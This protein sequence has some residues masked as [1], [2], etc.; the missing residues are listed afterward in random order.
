MPDSF[1]LE[2]SIQETGSNILSAAQD[3]V[4][5]F[6]DGKRWR[7]KM[8]EWA[9]K[10]ETFKVQLF[11]FIDALP[12]LRSDEELLR[13]LDE[14]FYGEEKLLP[15]GLEKWIPEGGILG[16]VA[17][18]TIKK[19]VQNLARQFIAGNNPKEAL[20][21]IKDLRKSGRTY[22]VDLLGE[23]VLSN[24][25]ALAYSE[26]Y[27]ALIE[28][29]HEETKSWDEIP[30]L[31]RI[32]SGPIPMTSIS[33]K[34][35][36]FC[37]HLDPVNW[38][39]SIREVIRGLS[40]VLGKA[41]ETGASVT[42][43]MEHYHIKDITFAIFK[44]ALDNFPALS[45][46][47]IAVQAYLRDSEK[48]L[49]ELIDWARKNN[50][51]IRVRL[52]KGAYWDYEKVINSQMRWPVPVYLNKAETDI[53]FER[54]TRILL[55]N[56]DC[57]RPAIASH[58]VR[59]VAHAMACAKI[60]SVPK[61][62]LEFQTLFGMADPFKN[63]V[64][65]MGYRV[66]EYLP[67]GK[68][69]P[70]MAYLVRRLLENTSNESFLRLSFVEKL[71]A[72]KLLAKPEAFPENSM[73]KPPDYGF[74]NLPLTDFSKDKNRSGFRDSLKELRLKTDPGKRPLII[75]G[76]KFFPDDEIVST[77]PARPDEIAG[78]VSKASMDDAERAV[79]FALAAKEGWQR[80]PVKERAG[81]L[82]SAANWITERRLELAALQV[83]EVG[84]SWKEADADVAEAVDFLNYYG[85]EMIRLSEPKK[86]GN[87]PGDLNHSVYI[88]RGVCAVISPW[89]F[90]LAIACGMTAAALVTGNP[91]ILKPSSLSPVTAY[92]L[93]E[94]F[95][96]SGLPEGVL[97]FLP[98]PGGEL[99]EFLVSHRDIDI[100]AFTGSMDVGLKIVELAAKTAPGQRNVKT[101][102][103]EMGGKNAII[104]DSSADL[105][106]AV[107]GVVDSFT[108]FQGQKC[109]AC[110]R[111]VV[112]EDVYDEF[113]ERLTL[114]VQSISI[115]PPE[116]PANIMGP[117]VD[118][119]A[120]E[121]FNRY[122]EIGSEE[123]AFHFSHS[124]IKP[125]EG[126][127]AA[128]V[129]FTDV[130]PASRLANEEIF[131]PLLS[132]IKAKDFDQ[133]LT[134]ANGTVYKLTGGIF[135]RSPLHIKRCREEFMVG[136]LYINRKITGALVGRQPFGGFGMS[137][138]G[139]KAGGSDY[140]LHFMYTR[141]ISEN[142]LRRGFIPVNRE[143]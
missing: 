80:T 99:G 117:L 112:L 87:Y 89:N 38:E 1:D 102:I 136:N 6:F 56:L 78:R 115:G 49:T 59:S 13:L 110:S 142:T 121:K 28:A 30:I 50:K 101:V 76:E 17:A 90:P 83:L 108:G 18:R 16:M 120:L 138:L 62:L 105:D 12:S 5:S 65:G 134:I 74:K 133:A 109:S 14:Y 107:K 48:D 82:F 125:K 10:D 23:A 92:R 91:V 37:P 97:Q 94:A 123:S 103:A 131:G 57:V 36:S 139:S 77:N 39:G 35:S 126:Y 55:D 63:A 116:D 15:P 137:G 104:V 96:S 33:L 20:K 113:V 3:Q 75:G 44:E 21:T 34:I 88:P 8:M 68:I 84:K 42:F 124:A 114:A 7:G 64:A 22:T 41:V 24:R 143:K 11:R 81:Y 9:M 72:A 43:D 31:D 25:E 69:L 51:V 70:G 118:A 98:G 26:R 53:N 45:L 61:D 127:F 40:P 2:S 58:N 106:E 129:I 119:S 86:L 60:A 71:G 100:I 66:R 52:V 111:A 132:V 140:L 27:L 19:N 79:T 32:K 141:C 47:G 4:P 93:M 73:D 85:L 54:L 46:A 135:S 128:P 122:V 95:E 29:L 67:V 130:T